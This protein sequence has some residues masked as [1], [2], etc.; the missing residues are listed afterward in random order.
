M[1]VRACRPKPRQRNL[2]FQAM[3]IEAD[4]RTSSGGEIGGDGSGGGGVS[5]DGDDQTTALLYEV[6]SLVKE[7]LG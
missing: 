5:S 3:D 1:R 6:D 2:S 4:E 7:P